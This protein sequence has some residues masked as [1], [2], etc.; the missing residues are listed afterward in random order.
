MP[1]KINDVRPF[2]A[3][4]YD[5][6]NVADIGLCLS[7]P[8][9]VISPSQQDAYYAQHPCNVIRLILNRIEKGDTETDN[10]YTR[11]RDLLKEWRDNGILHPTRAPSFWVY[12]QEFDL[13]G[14]G[15][16]T[17][18]GFIGAVRLRDYAER[19]ILPHEKVLKGPLEDRIRLTQVT[20]T[21]FEY[22]W[23]LYQ[24]KAY[25]IDNILD[26]QARGVPI[27]DFIERPIGVRHRLWR[28]VD[29]AT[30]EIIHRTM[31]RLKIYI[32]DGHHRYQTMLT[33]RDAMRARFPQAGPD[34]PWESI[35]MFLVNSEHEGL[36]ILPTH[37]MLDNI[38]VD[39]L[40]RLGVS[41]L[42]YFHVKKYAFRD[43]DEAEA[44]RRWLRDL[45]SCQPGE[46]KIGAYIVN[47]N[48][49]YLLTLR[50][51]E[52][53]EELVNLD[54]SSEWKLLDV[55]I[56]N[57]L[58]LEQILGITEEQLSLGK[59]ISYTKDVDEA[60]ARVHSGECQVALI[61]NSTALADVIIIAEND[62][63]MPRKSTH[64]YPKPVSGLVFYPM[65]PEFHAAG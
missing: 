38:Q 29:P 41:I 9:D 14:I 49:Y 54:F 32:A 8:Y 22:I 21:Q 35:M 7:Q 2:R 61:L 47:T 44:R 23:S 31:A 6:K 18:K 48:G 45:R 62:E 27:V 30:C 24:D 39:S 10:R 20:N 46:H 17:V 58:I 19:R 12:E 42:D 11:A 3:L 56:L 5:P 37:R 63:R 64:F 28:L 52:A 51:E 53:Y 33:V 25:I 59:N 60:L 65:D 34:A 43:G 36:T 26:E 4:H 55:N 40:Y 57:S 13:P 16:K 50:D 15:R 1:D